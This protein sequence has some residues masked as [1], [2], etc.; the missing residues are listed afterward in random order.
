MQ[1]KRKVNITILT[2]NLADPLVEI[3]LEDIPSTTDKC[4]RTRVVNA[5]LFVIP[6]YWEVPKCPAREAGTCT[7]QLQKK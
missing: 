6:K 7:V 5:V 2:L 3:H 1:F 4:T